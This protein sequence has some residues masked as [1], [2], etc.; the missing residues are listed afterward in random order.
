MLNECFFGGMRGRGKEEGIGGEELSYV[1]LFEEHR[2][3]SYKPRGS[4]EFSCL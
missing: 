3:I 2:N 1:I 4:V